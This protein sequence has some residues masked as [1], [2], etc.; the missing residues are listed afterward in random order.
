MLLHRLPEI[1]PKI[2]EF[3]DFGV[4]RDKV[5]KPSHTRASENNGV[6]EKKGRDR[7]ELNCF[8]SP[9]QQERI[10]NNV[11]FQV[12]WPVLVN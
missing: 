4:A 2:P 5:N 9:D 11:P 12:F 7:K 3:V 6:L 1:R 8:I 10:A